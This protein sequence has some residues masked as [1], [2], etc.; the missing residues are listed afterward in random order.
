M[1]LGWWDILAA[2]FSGGIGVKLLDYVYTEYKR[3]SEASKS[4]KELVNRHIDPI[5]KAADEIVGKI[6]SLAQSDFGE[7]LRSTGKKESLDSLMPYLEVLFL[8]AQF[9]SRIQ[10]LRMESIYL[11][12]GSDKTGK[13]LLMFIRALEATRTRLIDR[14]WQRGIGE[15]LIEHTGNGFCAISYYEFTKKYLSSEEFRTWI[16]PLMSILNRI[17]HTKERQRFL[18]YGVILH[19]LINTLDE[20][21]LLSR[22]RP[23]WANKLNVKSQKELRFRIFRIYLP[24]V[25]SPERYYEAGRK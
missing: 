10:I 25:K 23:G 14:G 24:F 5:L 21:H 9:W 7:V 15:A 3:R 6:R 2:G 1:N 12:L 11:N 20:K 8:F 19:A 17:N 18:V 13:R 4:A 16:K 22:D